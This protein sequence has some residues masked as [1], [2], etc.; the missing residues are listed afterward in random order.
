[1]LILFGLFFAVLLL[2]AGSFYWAVERSVADQ[3]LLKSSRQQIL[4]LQNFS[5]AVHRQVKEIADVLMLGDSELAEIETAGRQAKASLVRVMKE[6]AAE[7]EVSSERGRSKAEE[8]ELKERGEC[9]RL[10]ANYKGL[11]DLI[12]AALAEYRA[13]GKEK[14]LPNSLLP[15]ILDVERQFDGLLAAQIEDLIDEEV[16]QIEIREQFVLMHA[17]VFKRIAFL[18]CLTVLTVAIVGLGLLRRSLRD[19]AKQE[20]DAKA[21]NR[22]KSEFLANMSHKIRTPMTAILGFADILAQDQTDP[23]KIE[24]TQTIQQNGRHLLDII[25]DIL[26]LSKIDAGKFEVE[27]VPCSPWQIVAETSSLMRVRAAAK[28]IE[29]IVEY[30]GSLPETIQTSPIRIRQILI[31]LIGN[32]IK[33]TEVGSIWLVTHFVRGEEGKTQLH[34]D[35]VDTGIG[36]SKEEVEKIFQPFMQTNSSLLTKAQGTGLGLAISQRLAELLGGTID[37]ISRPGRGSTFSLTIDTGQLDGVKMIECPGEVLATSEPAAAKQPK[38]LH[39]RILLAEDGLDNQR[40]I[41][42]LLKKAGVEVTIVENGQ[43]AYD[44][45]IETSGK[46]TSGEDHDAPPPFDVILMDMQMPVMDGY[47]ATRRLRE[48]GYKGPIIALTAYAMSTDRQKCLD[49]GCNDYVIKPIAKD[50]FL[51]VLSCYMRAGPD[52]ERKCVTAVFKDLSSDTLQ[53]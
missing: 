52:M 48:M 12:E 1:M 30:Q 11:S 39:G 32:A 20:G 53:A 50:K 3:E 8:D 37:V 13:H 46:A 9:L 44:K 16:R 15:V 43:I 21:A 26:D 25:N 34:F 23:E 14:I 18:A 22:A 7:L 41:A 27:R 19:V 38:K 31:N 2:T 28:G 51:E 24:A 17:S 40:L 45:A 42:F 6:N 36:M 5:R 49:A 35:V 33:F 47:E 29:L 4:E 10:Q